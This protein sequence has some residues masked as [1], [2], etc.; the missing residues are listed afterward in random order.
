MDGFVKRSN[1]AADFSVFDPL[2]QP[3]PRSAKTYENRA[4]GP[5]VPK[6]GYVSGAYRAAHIGRLLPFT[7]NVRV[8]ENRS[9]PAP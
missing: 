9:A 5:S 3:S 7:E 2:S 8:P 4:R 1:S 6:N